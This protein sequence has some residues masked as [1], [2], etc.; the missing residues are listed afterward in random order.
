[1]AAIRCEAMLPTIDRAMVTERGIG[2][3]VGPETE[4]LKVEVEVAD[5]MI[6]I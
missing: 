4:K 6:Y 1:M 2:P 5:A 3:E